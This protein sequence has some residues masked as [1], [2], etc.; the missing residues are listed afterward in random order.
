MD[1]SI[2]IKTSSSD[3]KVLQC[4]GDTR[5]V[6][7]AQLDRTASGLLDSNGN[8]VQIDG[9]G[10]LRLEPGHYT[11]QTG[12][13]TKAVKSPSQ[14]RSPL[15]NDGFDIVAREKY[16]AENTHSLQTPSR[17]KSSLL[18]T[19]QGCDLASTRRCVV[20][21]RMLCL[22]HGKARMTSD[23]RQAQICVSCVRRSRCGIVWTKWRCLI[24]LLCIAFIVL[25]SWLVSKT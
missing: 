7:L 25:F 24:L 19:H 11:V 13:P 22:R 9:F 10:K 17:K 21:H 20:C 12:T 2:H 1:N 18:C 6:T 23:G 15:L 14:L 8:Q 5:E 3:T 16:I 4:V